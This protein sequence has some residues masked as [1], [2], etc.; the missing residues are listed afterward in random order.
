MRL[1]HGDGEGKS[2]RKRRVH[3]HELSLDRSVPSFPCLAVARGSHEKRLTR[4][5]L[6]YLSATILAAWIIEAMPLPPRICGNSLWNQRT[7][8][9]FAS[10]AKQPLGLS[11]LRDRGVD[12]SRVAA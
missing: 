8:H 1:G 6:R 3:H 10:R 5:L 12:P 7:K 2:F 11:V 4:V 9:G